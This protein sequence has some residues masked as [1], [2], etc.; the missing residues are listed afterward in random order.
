MVVAPVSIDDAGPDD[1]DEVLG[2][3]DPRAR[4]RY[5]VQWPPAIGMAGSFICDRIT[6]V[7][8]EPCVRAS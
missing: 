5:R 6:V 4:R 7:R 2:A 3:N 8:A 1:F